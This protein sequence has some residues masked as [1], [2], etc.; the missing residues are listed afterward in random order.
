MGDGRLQ[1]QLQ[2][3][4]LKTIGKVEKWVSQLGRIMSLT[5]GQMAE[6]WLGKLDQKL[7]EGLMMGPAGKMKEGG[8]S[9]KT[10]AV[11]VG[12]HG[13]RRSEVGNSWFQPS[14]SFNLNSNKQRTGPAGPKQDGEV[15]A[16]GDKA[17]SNDEEGHRAS[18]A[19]QERRAQS[20]LKPRPLVEANL[21]WR[22]VII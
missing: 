5:R 8:D 19:K 18:N 10:E 7:K 2:W 6:G 22:G 4:E 3:L 14:S 15:W 17:H 11:P 21:G 16:G 13:K 12:T 20:P 1:F 9:Q